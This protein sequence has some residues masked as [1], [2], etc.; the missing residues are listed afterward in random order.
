MYLYFKGTIIVNA[1]WVQA[2]CLKYSRSR[3]LL[4]LWDRE[5][6]KTLAK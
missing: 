2:K 3:L 4:S 5:T 6:V 1:V